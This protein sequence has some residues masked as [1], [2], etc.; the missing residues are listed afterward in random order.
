P[1]PEPP[2]PSRRPLPLIPQRAAPPRQTLSTETSAYT[3]SLGVACACASEREYWHCG[4]SRWTLRRLAF[5]ACRD[6]PGAANQG[7][8]RLELPML[9][10]LHGFSCLQAPIRKV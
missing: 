2:C 1:A 9:R 8:Q 3:I 5:C 10:Y 7:W 4:T 6:Q